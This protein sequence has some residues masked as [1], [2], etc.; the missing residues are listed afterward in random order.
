MFRKYF[1]CCG[2]I[3]CIKQPIAVI[4]NRVLL[5]QMS[6]V[7]RHRHFVHVQ[8]PV[9]VCAGYTYVRYKKTVITR[10]CKLTLVI[11]KKQVIG[12]T[13]KIHLEFAKAQEL[14]KKTSVLLSCIIVNSKILTLSLFLILGKL[15]LRLP[16]LK[17][18]RPKR[19]PNAH[20]PCI[21]EDQSDLRV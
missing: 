4:A 18:F 3:M 19:V 1:D 20:L 21:F 12:I 6:T 15:L 17:S 16:K 5:T 11:K 9:S 2:K 14:Q 7:V 13:S 10:V 8:F